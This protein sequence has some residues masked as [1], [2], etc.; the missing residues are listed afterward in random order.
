MGSQFSE[1]LDFAISK[2]IEAAELYE[3]Y[4][5]LVQAQE[6]KEMLSEMASMERGHEK[7]LKSFKEHGITYISKIGEINDL[8]L[9]DYMV[10][11]KLNEKSSSQD[12]LMFAMKAEQ[13]AA[14]LYKRLSDLEIDQPASSLFKSLSSEEMKHKYD[15]ESQYEKLFMQEN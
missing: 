2:E 8:H 12:A 5:S 10:T 7:K 6:A 14:D 1:I 13:K 9:S 11:N 15:L 4:A 3:K